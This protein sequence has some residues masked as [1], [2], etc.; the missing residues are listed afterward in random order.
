MMRIVL[1]S[2]VALL[3]IQ[4]TFAGDCLCSCC[5]SKS[6]TPSYIGSQYVWFCSAATC[7]RDKCVGSYHQN[8]PPADAPG[9]TEAYCRNGTERLFS[10]LYILTGLISMILLIKNQ[11]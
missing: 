2:F 6:C 4:Q 1:L 11:L 7:T 3:L 10:S 5:T 9:I 8:C